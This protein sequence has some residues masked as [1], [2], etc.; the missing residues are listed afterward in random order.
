[1]VNEIKADGAGVEL[2]LERLLDKKVQEAA[3]NIRQVA[4]SD[5]ID[6]IQA[7][8][9]SNIEDKRADGLH[10]ASFANYGK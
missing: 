1:M 6:L 8:F 7:A 9:E 2:R 10:M 4:Q 5:C 3:N